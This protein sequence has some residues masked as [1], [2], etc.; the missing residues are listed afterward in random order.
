M[1]SLDRRWWVAAG[2]V[3]IVLAA[4]IYSRLTAPP[5]E[6]EPVLEL[7]DYNRA[8]AAAIR[9][10]SGDAEG[11]PTPPEE[12]AYQQ[13][14]DGLAER[15]RNIDRDD[16]RI[17]AVDVADLAAV[18]VRTM[19]EVREAAEQRAPGAPPPP[20]LYELTVLDG[21]LQRKLGELADACRG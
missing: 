19:R 18:F 14:A 11:L 9:E 4:L 13:W 2:V 7:L 10:K 16:L 15:A 8:Q 5:P 21:Q 3:A 6:C 20:Q 1:R 17:A 12:L